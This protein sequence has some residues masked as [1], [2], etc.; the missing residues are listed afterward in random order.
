MFYDLNRF[1]DQPNAEGESA[2]R[3]Y[4]S[5]LTFDSIRRAGSPQRRHPIRSAAAPPDQPFYMHSNC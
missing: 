2:C 1:D 5:E 4:D 3:W